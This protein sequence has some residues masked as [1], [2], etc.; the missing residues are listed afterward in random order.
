MKHAKQLTRTTLG[1]NVKIMAFLIAIQGWT[2]YLFA[3]TLTVSGI[4]KFQSPAIGIQKSASPL[5][6]PNKGHLPTPGSHAAYRHNVPKQTVQH[7]NIPEKSRL[8]GLSNYKDPI[9]GLRNPALTDTT[10]EGLHRAYPDVAHGI[11]HTSKD[12]A[13]RE[14]KAKKGKRQKSSRLIT[15]EYDKDGIMT[16]KT[17]NGVK[18]RYVVDKNRDYPVVLE[19]RNESGELLVS[20]AYGDDLISQNR[21]GEVRYFHYDGKM[22][23]R[24]LT[25]QDGNVTDTYTYD[26]FGNVLARQR[27]II[28]IPA[29]STIRTQVFTTF[30]QGG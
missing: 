17:V 24:Q 28:F 15:Y 21:G 4:C 8:P 13:A 3:E 23:T 20:Y 27:T 12:L 9:P 10:G 6:S 11:P 7:S 5:Y 25:D 18:T 1:F 2:G 22:S 26:A 29:N 30:A 14:S 19:E 16:A